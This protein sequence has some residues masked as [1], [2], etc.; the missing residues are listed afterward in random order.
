MSGFGVVPVGT[1]V[2][3][4]GGFF[5]GVNNAGY[6]RTL[7]AT[8]DVAGA[9]A[10]LTP[11]GWRVCDG[12]EPSDS[13]SLIWNASG[14]KVPQLNDRRFLQGSSFI[15]LQSGSAS[16]PVDA[17]NTVGN[18]QGS[19]NTIRDHLHGAGTAAVSNVNIS[20]NHVVNTIAGTLVAGNENSH[21]HGAA[22]LGTGGAGNHSHAWPPRQ[23]GGYEGNWSTDSAASA[24]VSGGYGDG[25]QNTDSDGNA[26]INA[27]GAGTYAA[28]ASGGMNS[29]A[30]HAHRVSFNIDTPYTGNNLDFL[31]GSTQTIAFNSS[32]NYGYA[33]GG[34]N[35]GN[36]WYTNTDHTHDYYLPSHRHWIK[37]R[38]T[39]DNPAD[40]SHSV[41][42]A[43]AAGDSH[44][45]VMSGAV[46]VS[47]GTGQTQH[48]HSLTGNVGTGNAPTATE[49]RPQYLRC[50][51]IIR[52]K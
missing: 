22:G 32:G 52:I 13:I 21:T 36:T 4:V 41:T 37:T 47:T 30:S 14:K 19:L 11:M 3:W 49:N 8:D 20:H 50:F 48:T 51:M 27:W 16:D 26:G 1:I 17:L 25:T 31:G 9:N 46:D 28:R 6:I 15:A 10:Y 38:A 45:H 43:T 35:D 29:N 33:T 5:S 23:A 44:T 39:T 40:H 42:G 7:G 2:G 12:G 24:A 34:G 18:I